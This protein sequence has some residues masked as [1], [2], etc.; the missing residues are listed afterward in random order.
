M[1]ILPDETEPEL[2][3]VHGQKQAQRGLIT[4]LSRRRAN[5]LRN[6]NLFIFKD[7][8]Q[9]NREITQTSLP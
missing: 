6:L 2:S 4:S 3:K 7:E 1:I 8:I 9:Y 5:I